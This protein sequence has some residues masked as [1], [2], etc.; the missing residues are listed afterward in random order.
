MKGLGYLPTSETKSRLAWMHSELEQPR[1]LSETA[2]KY[3]PTRAEDTAQGQSTYLAAIKA[4]VLL[5]CHH[6][7][8]QQKTPSNSKHKHALNTIQRTLN[9]HHSQM[10]TLYERQEVTGTQCS[11]LHQRALYIT[12]NGNRRFK[13]TKSQVTIATWC[14]AFPDICGAEMASA[15]LTEKSTSAAFSKEVGTKAGLSRRLRSASESAQQTHCN[16]ELSTVLST[17]DSSLC[18]LVTL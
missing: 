4:R 13:C 15:P 12:K 14:N 5:Q 9:C 18:D 11:S 2:S 16:E 6:K 7:T 10:T 17:T 3:K 1:Q 8:K